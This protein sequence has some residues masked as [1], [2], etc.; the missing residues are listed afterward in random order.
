[1]MYQKKKD[2]AMSS[3]NPAKV[4]VTEIKTVTSFLVAK[5]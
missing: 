4:Y 5:S 3:E 1:M 2:L